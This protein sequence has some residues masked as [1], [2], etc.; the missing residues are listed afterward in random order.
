ME[1]IIDIFNIITKENPTPDSSFFTTIV[2]IVFSAITFVISLSIIPFQKLSESVSGYL[3]KILIKDKKL[4]ISVS[5]TILISFSELV[6]LIFLRDCLLTRFLY[7]LG[8]LFVFIILFIYSIDILRKLD[9]TTSIFEALE[10]H[11][12]KIICTMR[13]SE[14]KIK[15]NDLY[16]YNELQTIMQNTILSQ[17]NPEKY[18]LGNIYMDCEKIFSYKF[19]FIYELILR[20]LEKNDYASYEASINGLE[21][22]LNIYFDYL[23]NHYII[24][25]QFFIDFLEHSKII[26]NECCKK[27]NS[28]YFEYYCILIEKIIDK[29]MKINIPKVFYQEKIIDF[30]FTTIY[31]E[32]KSLADC[33]RYIQ[34]SFV[35]IK[36]ENIYKGVFESFINFFEQLILIIYK[37][38]N[39]IEKSSLN[40]LINSFTYEVMSCRNNIYVPDIMDTLFQLQEKEDAKQLLAPMLVFDDFTTDVVVGFGKEDK[41]LASCVVKFLLSQEE[42]ENENEC[43]QRNLYRLELVD[44]VIQIL[45]NR[46]KKGGT[47]INGIITQLFVIYFNIVLLLDENIFKYYTKSNWNYIF[48][49]EEKEKYLAILL[50]IIRFTSHAKKNPLP[51]NNLLYSELKL[52]T[53]LIIEKSITNLTLQEFIWVQRKDI[54]NCILN[55]NQID[56]NM[57]IEI[58]K[59]IFAIFPKKVRKH[60]LKNIHKLKKKQNHKFGL[61]IQSFNPKQLCLQ[62]ITLFSN[63]DE[64]LKNYVNNS[65]NNYIKIKEN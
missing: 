37:S 33:T 5:L 1:K 46:Y 39:S 22:S 59:F 62:G 7:V 17:E 58:Y 14:N 27:T 2:T 60:I 23:N 55:N 12:N 51:E 20:N 36:D 11:L 43:K 56:Q 15:Q 31:I 19:S 50:Q 10:K 64:N 18:P 21:K 42:L 47:Y 65:I 44:Q 38:G 6:Y 25:D 24:I 45:A 53:L 13:K 54:F 29:I 16:K 48:S 9:I 35:F 63:T 34:K 32:K 28:L 61:Y 52:L 41:T 57:I 26:I 40:K 4:I 49:N 3:Y 30:I 8:L